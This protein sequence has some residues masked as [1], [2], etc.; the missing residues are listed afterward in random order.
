MKTFSVGEVQK[1]FSSVLKNINAGEE[2]TVTKRGKPVAKIRALGP[3]H[4]I[5]RP[6]FYKDGIDLKGKP[7]RDIVVSS[8]KDRF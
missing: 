4:H 3:K 7:M 1:N 5:K 8:R 2:V 6:D